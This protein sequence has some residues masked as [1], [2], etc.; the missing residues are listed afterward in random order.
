MKKKVSVSGLALTLVL[1]S[2]CTDSEETAS[3]EDA[4]NAVDGI[5][6]YIQDFQ[7]EAE[8]LLNVEEDLQLDFEEDLANDSEGALLEGTGQVASN[9][10][11]REEI[12]QSL[13]SIHSQIN[14]EL[15]T[16]GQ[17]IEHVDAEELPN[18]IEEFSVGLSD[19]GAELSQFIDEYRHNLS[20]QSEYFETLSSEEADF[21]DIT[22]GIENVNDTHRAMN[23][24][25]YE[26]EDTLINMQ[27]ILA[28]FEM[29]TPEEEGE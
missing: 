22:D 8:Q 2:A 12:L 21:A 28:N 16:I 15:N 20:T 4:G 7:T 29:P 10:S 11:D 9:L 19:Y 24:S 5:E 23:A 1:L 27:E 18:D 25:W 14:Q 3:A 26:L 17:A 6:A 13:D